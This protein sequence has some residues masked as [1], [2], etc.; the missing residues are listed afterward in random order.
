MKEKGGEKEGKLTLSNDSKVQSVSD[1]NNIV[2]GTK[3][4]NKMLSFNP[5]SE[6][7]IEALDSSSSSASVGIFRC[8][9]F[10]A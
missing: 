7:G 3:V 1:S 8:T 2:G 6:V 4:P 10:G 9:F 5:S